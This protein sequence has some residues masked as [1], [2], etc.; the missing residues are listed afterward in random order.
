MSAATKLDSG[1]IPP[2]KLAARLLAV[3][4]RYWKVVSMLLT[5]AGTIA[6]VLYAT[7]QTVDAHDLVL[8]DHASKL[9]RLENMAT[10]TYINAALACAASGARGCI[11]K[12][13]L[14]RG[15]VPELQLV[16]DKQ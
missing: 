7:V 5:G 3:A 4:V 1:D 9:A 10:A 14:E 16:G 11:D 15:D 13:R 12:D 6:A 8:R 2:I